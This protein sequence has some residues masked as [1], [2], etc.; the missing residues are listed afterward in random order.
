LCTLWRFENIDK[1]A[2]RLPDLPDLSLTEHTNSQ[3]KPESTPESWIN[4]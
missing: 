3:S 4:G 1:K 2:E